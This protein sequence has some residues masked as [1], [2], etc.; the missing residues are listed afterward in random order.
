MEVA[1]VDR[2]PMGVPGPPLVGLV[3][4]AELQSEI[5]TKLLATSTTLI[6]TALMQLN[7][8]ATSLKC[9]K[10]CSDSLRALMLITTGM[11]IDKN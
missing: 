1:P 7:A 5:Q 2:V 6:F 8:N 10:N 3:G 9:A 11:L 4:R